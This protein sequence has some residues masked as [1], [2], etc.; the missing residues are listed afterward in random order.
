MR[1]L[2]ASDTF[3][4]SAG[5]AANVARRPSQALRQ[6]G[7]ETTLYTSDFHLQQGYF[8]SLPDIKTH[9]GNNYLSPRGK[10]LLVPGSFPDIKVNSLSL[11]WHVK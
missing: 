5:G 8:T 1:I 2:Q 9:I 4:P 10:P 11:D 7:H 3:S 6:P